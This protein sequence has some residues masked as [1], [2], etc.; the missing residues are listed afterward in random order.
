[1]S[2]NDRI[3]LYLSCKV[4]LD[5]DCLMHQYHLVFKRGLDAL[6]FAIRIGHGQRWSYAATLAKLMHVWRDNAKGVYSLWNDRCPEEAK[7]ANR[8]PPQLIGGS[9]IVK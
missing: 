9:H 6:S 8:R 1:M 5:C 7:M 3:S 2:E 4:M